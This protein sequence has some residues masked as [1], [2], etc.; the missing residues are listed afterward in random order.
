MKVPTLLLCIAL[1]LSTGCDSN[2]PDD[3]T[4][5]SGS[6][7][8]TVSGDVNKTVNGNLATFG[9]GLGPAAGH[10]AFGLNLGSASDIFSIARIAGQP[11]TGMHNIQDVANTND[12]D[13]LPNDFGA[14]YLDDTAGLYASTSGSVTITR[15][16][17]NVVEG[18]F[19]VSLINFDT[20]NPSNISITGEFVAI[21][22]GISPG[23]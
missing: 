8:M 14:T 12:D 17:E 16:D 2:D 3:P 15:S 20:N 7:T 4:P 23:G 13:W 21:G 11:G 10:S 9:A 18:S 22:L 5:A 19:T 1:F 6:F